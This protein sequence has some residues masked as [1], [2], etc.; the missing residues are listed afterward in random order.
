MS[1]AAEEEGARQGAE[2]AAQD[3]FMT[4]TIEAANGS[5]PAL[6]AAMQAALR[7]S[8]DVYSREAEGDGPARKKVGM[9]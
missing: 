4:V 6:K 2:I 3:D 8:D 7:A 9:M 5:M 1:S